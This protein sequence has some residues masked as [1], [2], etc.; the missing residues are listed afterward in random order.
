MNIKTLSEKIHHSN[1]YGIFFEMGAGI[2]ISHNLMKYPG[3]S[4][5]VHSVHSLYSKEAYKDHFKL[6][7][8]EVAPRAVSKGYCDIVIENTKLPKEVNFILVSSF[9]LP[10]EP[11]E[12][13][14]G[15]IGYYSTD[16]QGVRFYH[17]SFPPKMSRKEAIEEVALTG[18]NIINANNQHCLYSSYIDRVENRTDLILDLTLQAFTSSPD[19]NKLAMFRPTEKDSWEASRIETSLRSKDN[20]VVYKGSFNP[21]HAGHQHTMENSVKLYPEEHTTQAL[22]ISID[23][24]GK[25]EITADGLLKRLNSLRSLGYPVIVITKPYFSDLTELILEKVKGT[26][27]LAMGDDVMDKV[28]AMNDSYIFSHEKVSAV[29]VR[30]H[31]NGENNYNQIPG[32]MF[33]DEEPKPISSTGI[34]NQNQN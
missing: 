14:H 19:K 5:T 11:S 13:K 27:F 24:Y 10:E 23:T 22:S 17:L 3:A 2:G 8:D 6:P 26:L 16:G 9:Q 21:W 20:I 32:V 31:T 4:S 33:I 34:R 30:R 7:Q 12:T 1:R 25:G 15:W 28:I 29:V 18:L